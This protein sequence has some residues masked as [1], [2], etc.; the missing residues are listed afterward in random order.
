MG[1]AIRMT[2]KKFGYLL[3]LLTFS[4]ALIGCTTD[5]SNPNTSEGTKDDAVSNKAGGELNFAYHVQPSTLDPHFTTADATR[6]VSHHIFE[7]LLTLNSSLEI[8]PMLAETYEVSKDRKTITFHLRKKIKFHN[9]DEMTADDVVASMNR[10]QEKSAQ[11][12]IYLDGTSYEAVDQYTVVAHIEKPTSLDMFVLAD[13]TQYAAIMPQAIVEKAGSNEVDEYIG[14][15]PY[16]FKEW[17]QDQFIQLGKF[18]DYQSRSEPADGLAGEKKAFVDDIYF[19][20]VTDPSIRVAGLQS[21]Q[22]QIASDIPPDSAKTLLNDKNIKSAIDASAFTT[23]VF[24]KK[25][26]V[27]SNLKVRQAANAAI[28][29]EDMLIAAYVSDEFYVKDHALVKE[30]QTG[31]Y[32]DVG[33]DVY[34]KYDPEVAKRLLDEAGYNGEEVVILT[35][36]EYSN[37]YNMSVVVQQQLQAVGMNVKLAVTD[38]ATVLAAR[39]DEKKFDI[40]FTSFTIR[41]IPIQYLFLNPE[42]FGWTDSE[43]IKRIVDDILNAESEEEAQKFSPDLHRAFWDY[44]PIIKPGNSTLITSMSKDVDGFQFISNPILW[45]VSLNE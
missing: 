43:E 19:H 10:W 40:F 9:G 29:V 41:P 17:R 37:Y 2:T 35:S 18:S 14:T 38:W 13:M 3:L 25:A 34:N 27:F 16:K 1:G 4:I 39:E 22:Y 21:G 15:G 11:A 28:N 24:N 12:T 45:N 5:K 26:G 30:E 42:W 6:D 7:S 33:S 44:L 32:T 23:M 36:R 8:Q 20:L 31:W